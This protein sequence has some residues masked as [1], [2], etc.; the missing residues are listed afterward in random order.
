MDACTK[1]DEYMVYRTNSRHTIK[2][3][4]P[5]MLVAISFVF[6]V[7]GLRLQCFHS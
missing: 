1:K 3:F 6:S 5:K 7:L 2:Q 4:D